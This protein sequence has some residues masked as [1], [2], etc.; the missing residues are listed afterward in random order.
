MHHRQE[1][2]LTSQPTFRSHFSLVLF[3]EDGTVHT[4]Q[5]ISELR[6]SWNDDDQ[7]RMSSLWKMM[8]RTKALKLHGGQT[9]WSSIDGGG[10][11]VRYCLWLSCGTQM[12][13][14]CRYSNSSKKKNVR[15]IA[16]LPQFISWKI[17]GW[18]HNPSL[19]FWFKAQDCTVYS[20]WPSSP[21]FSNDVTGIIQDLAKPRG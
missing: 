10:L 9:W 19:P 21:F 17:P 6:K 3:S 1:Q 2:S 20:F 14:I 8:M 11:R 5:Y 7:K 12:S 18:Y 13:L 4:V 16:I 15:I